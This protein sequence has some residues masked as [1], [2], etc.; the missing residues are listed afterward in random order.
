VLE[1]LRRAATGTT[2]VGEPVDAAEVI[3]AGEVLR[4]LG[5][6]LRLPAA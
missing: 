1:Q 5:E 3:A 2:P 6:P 4:R